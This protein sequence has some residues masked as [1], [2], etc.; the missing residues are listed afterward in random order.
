MLDAINAAAGDTVVVKGTRLGNSIIDRNLTLKGVNKPFGTATLRGR[1][2]GSVVTVN[3]GVTVAINN[4]TITHGN[5]ASGGGIY[6]ASAASRDGRRTATADACDRG[7][8]CTPA[9]ILAFA[10]ASLRSGSVLVRTKLTA[11]GTRA[12][13]SRRPLSMQSSLT[14]VSGA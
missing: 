1:N 2:N 5:T 13:R 11:R 12:A 7:E 9:L 14:R 10:R 4:L 6:N 3:P 8:R